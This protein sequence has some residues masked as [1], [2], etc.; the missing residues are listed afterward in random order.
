ML[1]PEITPEKTVLPSSLPTVS[2]DHAPLLLVTEPAPLSEPTAWLTPLRSKAALLEITRAV[3]GGRTL[4][5]D[6]TGTP[7]HL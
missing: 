5:T 7:I 4:V 3:S 6:G 1:E 2:V